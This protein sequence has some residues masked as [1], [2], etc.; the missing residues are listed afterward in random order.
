[1]LTRIIIVLLCLLASFPAAAGDITL[2]ADNGVEYHQNEQKLVARGNAR[3]AKDDMSIRAE[4]L[5]GFYN[6]KVKNKLSRLEA[7]KKVVMKTSRADADGDSLVYDINEDTAVLKG[8]PAHIKLPDADI[9]A[10]GCITYYQSKKQAV[11][12]DGV[13][14]TDA[15]GN[16]VYADLMTA[17]FVT[18]ADDK[19]VLD[20]IDIE[21]NV[22]I[23]SEDTVVT[24]LRGIYLAQA[25]KINLFDDV[26]INQ[27]G[28]IL[29][30]SKA[31]TDL[32]T[33]ISKILSGSGSKGRVSGVF[34]EKKK[35]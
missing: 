24:A 1:M 16:K 23:I 6:P 34:K 20:R 21:Q 8:S 18:G 26:V 35:E 30:G 27:S 11:A 29:K 17:Y 12:R 22:K 13:V 19:L 3:A 7:Y 28:N 33:G 25:G 31:E 5:V 15:K 4:T 32:N 14:A 10:K 2:D 9:T